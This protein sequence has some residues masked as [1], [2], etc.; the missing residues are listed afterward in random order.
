MA[1][2]QPELFSAHPELPELDRYE[3]LDTLAQV[4]GFLPV[5]KAEQVEVMGLQSVIDTPG[6]AAKHLAEVIVR[7]KKEG[8]EDPGAAAR[9]IVRS[10]GEWAL[11]AKNSVNSLAALRDTLADANPELLLDRVVEPSDPGVLEFL[12]YF[13]LSLLREDGEGALWELGY[14]PQAFKYSKDN[15]GIL[16]YAGE[17]ASVWRVHQVR[18][19]LPNAIDDQSGR[20]T[21]FA[22]RLT[23]VIDHSDKKLAAIAHEARDKIFD[24]TEVE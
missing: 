1:V 14:D 4:T 3:R 18:K 10:Y 11:D 23:E 2:R 16:F 22:Q 7:R 17:A 5:E 8:A 19:Q 6:G 21:F 20:F 15:P 13:D 9:K 24:R 12:R